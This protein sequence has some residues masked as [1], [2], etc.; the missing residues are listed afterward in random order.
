MKKLNTIPYNQHVK[1]R[2]INWKNNFEKSIGGELNYSAIAKMMEERFS[3]ST[4]PQ[5]IGAMF[6]IMSS[7]EVKLQEV[8]ALS[9]IFSIPLQDIC[10][11]PNTPTQNGDIDILIKKRKTQNNSVSQTINTFYSGDYYCYYFQPK[12]YDERLKP[13]EQAKIEEAKLN[14]SIVDGHTTIVLHEL[15][16]EATFYGDIRPS[17][18]LSGYL[19]HF[20]NPDIA[21]SFI[22]DES[23]RRAM[24]IMFSY[25]ELSSDIRYYI[26]AAILTFSI[27]Q[28]HFPVCEKM[29][30]FRVRQ[31]LSNETT[32]ETL[33]GILALNTNPI[34][35]DEETRNSLI[36]QS[37]IFQR[38]LSEDKAMAKCYVYSESAFRSN[39][40]FITDEYKKTE[41]LLK[42][43]KNSLCATQEVVNEDD[44]FAQFIKKY[45][46]MQ[47]SEINN[48]KSE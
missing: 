43:K 3:I 16:K 21:Y 15:K 13:V 22:K 44:L 35:I 19:Y 1:S 47:L 18:T 48:I 10:E 6:D 26:P 37:P 9:Q 45:Q 33:R 24:A 4:S 5:K 30:I 39:M 34:C 41:I 12:L 2:L 36:S 8:V 27:N 32:N 17:F 42:L 38:L 46:Q 20:E 11:F 14:I 40:F 31:D 7:R 29:A 25:F 23:G 28:I